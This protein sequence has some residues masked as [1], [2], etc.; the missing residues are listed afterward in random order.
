MSIRIVVAEDSS[1]QRKIIADIIN[2]QDGMEVVGI[3][4][5]GMETLD[6]VERFDPDVLLLD[7]EMP[8]M[9]GLEAFNFLSEHYLLPT[10]V[11][12]SSDPRTLD[13]ETQTILLGA[14]DYIEKP[15]GILKEEL[16]KIKEQLIDKII[17]ASKMNKNYT[18]FRDSFR[19]AL[20]ELKNTL[21]KEKKRDILK[22]IEPPESKSIDVEYMKEKEMIVGSKVS[23]I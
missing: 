20:T 16:P 15:G 13:F 14:V 10:I 1:Y 3:A 8:K 22:K 7:L 9:S 4:R 21:E 2:S 11:L 5:N 12:S 23:W 17:V 19:S 6:K 18:K